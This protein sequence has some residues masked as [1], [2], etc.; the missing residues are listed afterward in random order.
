MPLAAALCLRLLHLLYSITLALSSCWKRSNRPQPLT[1]SRKRLPNHIA[2]ALLV[3]SEL[4]TDESHSIISDA[5]ANA[6]GW[7]RTV[8]IERL[9]I[10]DKHGIALSRAST[11]RERVVCVTDD[12]YGANTSSDSEPDYPLTPPLSDCSESRPLSPHEDISPETAAV[13]I[14]IPEK[15]R[16]RSQFSGVSR[17]RHT[18]RKSPAFQKITL[19]LLSRQCS[20]PAIAAA[21]TTIAQSYSQKSRKSHRRPL[22]LDVDQLNSV[23]QGEHG[24]PPPDFLILQPMTPD[25]DTRLPLE[26]HGFPPWHIKLTEIYYN[27]ARG[28]RGWLHWFLQRP[29]KP[30]ALDES[31]IGTEGNFYSEYVEGSTG[32]SLADK[33]EEAYAF[34]AHNFYP[35]DEVFLFGFSRGAYTARM[36]AMFIGEIGILDHRDMDH[37]ASI[38]LTYQKL[39]KCKEQ[40]EISVLKEKLSPWTRH[41]SPGKLRADSDQDT[42]SIK[43]IGVFDT[44]GSLG[45]PGE[46]TLFSKHVQSIFGFP[47]KK[48]GE[49]I[50]RAYQT[51]ALNETRADFNC[52]KFEQTEGGRR[53]NQILKQ[54]WFT[55]GGYH[56]HD[57]SDLTLTWMA[58]QIGDI[59]S[60]DLKYLGSLFRPTAPWGEQKPHDPTTGIFSMARVIKRPIPA[61]T[62]EVTHETIHASVL[63]QAAAYP[64]LHAILQKNPHIIAPLAPLEEEVK[65]NWPFSSQTTAAIQAPKPLISGPF[66]TAPLKT[67]ALTICDGSNGFKPKEQVLERIVEERILPHH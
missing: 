31:G 29:P 16:R 62:D 51:L 6:V 59:L 66:T 28:R 37:F 55:G 33:V 67:E 63:Q 61:S 43:C 38:F 15:R 17:R 5:I 12:E 9:T 39:G 3:D 44:V 45:L 35:G 50:E 18:H 34:I 1:A 48:L 58:A 42:Y 23:L 26:L 53:K 47:D 8:G 11:I 21:A 46:L 30:A 20:K 2:I 7:C 24:F 13:V 22:R 41:D 32:G 64:D 57:L 36:V 25:M 65:L 10:Y 54:C 60:L 40:K 49:H 4:Q 52:T 19:S 14:Q 27:R 56:E